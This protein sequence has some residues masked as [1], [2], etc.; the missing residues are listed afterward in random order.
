MHACILR[1][2]FPRSSR[3]SLIAHAWQPP[4]FSAEITVRELFPPLG[5]RTCMNAIAHRD[6]PAV[7]EAGAKGCRAGAAAAPNRPSAASAMAN[8]GRPRAFNTI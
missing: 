4:P 8:S 2:I 5:F 7:R 1:L 6:P 3:L